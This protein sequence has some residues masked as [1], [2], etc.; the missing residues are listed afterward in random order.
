MSSLDRLPPASEESEAAFLGSCLINSDGVDAGLDL[1]LKGDDFYK[2]DY[3][4][5]WRAM[6]SLAE[7]GK[8]IDIVTVSEW[9]RKS[10]TGITASFVT[11]LMSASP[12]SMNAV[13]YAQIIKDKSMRR[14]LITAA[15]NI[16]G[17][18][19]DESD[20]IDT[21]LD[22]ADNALR[23]AKEKAPLSG[24]D[25]DPGD[26]LDRM[27]GAKASGPKTRL[28]AL[29]AITSGMTP[30]H[31][32][33]VG[34]FSSTGKSAFGVNLVEDVVLAGGSVMIAS[35]EMTQEQYMLRLM[36]LTSGVP[37]RKIRYGGMNM[38]EM[39]A[40]QQSREFWKPAKIRIYDDLYNLT[41]IRRVAQ[42]VRRELGGL[43]MLMVDFIQNINET[44]DEVKDARIAA[45]KL[46]ALA[47]ELDT[48]V[49]AMS[50]ISNAQAIQQNE[51]GM[52][53]YYAFKGS[54]AIKDAAD[55]AIML[56]RDRKNAP[57]VLW[58][59]VV[60]NRH[61]SLA[62]IGTKFDLPT[63]S[64]QQMTDEEQFDA[65][66]NSGRRSRRNV[67]DDA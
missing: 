57:E 50:Q 52:G 44:G 36:S 54:G 5:V 63:G 38:E 1:N 61:D 9:L 11:G 42:R 16:S 22:K 49:I 66:P 15:S 27:E 40:Y 17:F 34:G 46:Q 29:N 45:I 12:T 60:K 19:F 41:R 48:C 56:D 67:D 47:K 53:N 35:T 23:T 10:N 43:D 8:A 6:Q 62:T 25:P 39:A 55:L 32:W 21:M 24:N 31:I 65:D 64:V 20:D 2:Q 37:Q 4:M 18:A 33:V 28:P 7:R 58:V 13:H 30:G 3:G 59:Y 26:I 14:S 51:K